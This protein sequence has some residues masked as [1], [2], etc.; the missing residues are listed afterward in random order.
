MI[1]P[2]EP[3]PADVALDGIGEQLL[4]LHRVG[5]IEPQMTGAPQFPSDA[6]IQADRF[7]VS[8]MQESVRLRRE[9]RDHV[10]HAPRVQIRLHDVTDEVASHLGRFR[11]GIHHASDSRS[12]AAMAGWTS[13][14]VHS[15]RQT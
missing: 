1:A 11:L 6:E 12:T 13:L 5:V 4:L 3:Q 10:L 15:I 8:Q 7:G 2:V 9:A 14:Y